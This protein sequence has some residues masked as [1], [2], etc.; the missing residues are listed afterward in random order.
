MLNNFVQWCQQHRQDWRTYDELDL[1]LSS[2]RSDHY[3]LGTACNVGSQTLAAIVHVTP[4]LF[5]QT[6]SVLP[7]ASRA[8]AA[9]KRRAPG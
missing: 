6:V 1:G 9:W 3:L 4:S 8:S 2:C 7:R 5:R